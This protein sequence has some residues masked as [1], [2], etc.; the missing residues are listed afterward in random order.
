MPRNSGKNN[1]NNDSAFQAERDCIDEQKNL[2]RSRAGRRAMWREEQE[3]AHW[4][5]EQVE[6]L[7]EAFPNVDYQLV[8]DQFLMN[9]QNFH[10]TVD[11][12]VK[13]SENENG[14]EPNRPMFIRRSSQEVSQEPNFMN[15]QQQNLG[16]EDQFPNLQQDEWEVL[17]TEEMEITEEMFEERMSWADK[18]KKNRH[19][20][21]TNNTNSRNR[22]PFVK[23]QS[24]FKMAASFIEPKENSDSDEYSSSFVMRKGQAPRN[25]KSKGLILDPEG[26]F[27]EE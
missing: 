4:V 10:A 3:D 1:R 23:P 17:D 2:A 11:V 27:N 20:R 8:R 22:S 12:L 13:L 21:V 19:T 5:E 7:G 14:P 26:L 18:V 6:R 25:R 15:N 16:N 9:D 24:N